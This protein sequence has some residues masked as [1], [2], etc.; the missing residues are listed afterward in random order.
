MYLIPCLSCGRDWF[1]FYKFQPTIYEEKQIFSA[2]TF[3]KC[4]ANT[5]WRRLGRWKIVTL[6]TS[7]RHKQ[8]IFAGVREMFAGNGIRS[9][10]YLCNTVSLYLHTLLLYSHTKTYTWLFYRCLELISINIPTCSFLQFFCCS[11]QMPIDSLK[12]IILYYG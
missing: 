8:E 12:S 3:L 10:Q 6:K 1:I 9:C 11:F 4:L 2:K 5:S 7:S